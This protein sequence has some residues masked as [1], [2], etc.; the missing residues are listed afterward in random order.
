MDLREAAAVQAVLHA[1]YVDRTPQALA[2]ASG[3]AAWLAE[4]AAAPTDGGGRDT[5]P[6]QLPAAD[7]R[8]PGPAGGEAPITDFWVDASP[9]GFLRLSA[10]CVHTIGCL[11]EAVFDQ[12]RATLGDLAAAAA[13][14]TGP[15]A[16]KMH[17]RFAAEVTSAGAP[18]NGAAPVIWTDTGAGGW[19]C[20]APVPGRPDSI[21]GFRVQDGSCPDHAAGTA[22]AA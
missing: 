3:Q 20:A 11:F 21:C 7:A 10:P 15:E 22:R 18:G 12:G 2:A 17:A 19:V 14:H 9:L 5:L 1:A 13:A 16:A 8:L 6:A 4:R